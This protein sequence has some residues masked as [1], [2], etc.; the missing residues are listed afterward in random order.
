M[1]PGG[2]V[3]SGPSDDPS[4]WWRSAVI[5]QV[6]PRSFCD[7]DGDGVGDLAGVTAHLDH[8]VGL[9]VDALWL[10]PIF[11]S[12]MADFGYDVAD[13]CGVDPQ[14][15]TLEDF[16]AL[17]GAAHEAGLKL[18]LDWVPNHTSDRHPW[19]L[20][21]RSRPSSPR[22]DWYIWRR[23]EG[24]PPNNWRAAFPGVG[25]HQFPPA[26]TLDEAS[27]EWYLHLF[28]A[29][30]PDLNW[31]HPQVRQAMAETLRFWL[32]RGV[33]GFR[34][35]VIHALGKDPRLPDLPADL[36]AIPICALIDDP[37]THRY[38]ADIRTV[39][40]DAAPDAVVIGETVLP[41]VSQVGAFYGDP[42]RPEL[43]LAF[44]FHPLHARW[45]APTWRE[46][47]DLVREHILPVGWPAWALGNHDNPRQR[48]RYGS[49]ARARA[50]A[51][52]L[53]TLPG[54]PFLY[55]GE[56]LGLADAVVGPD[57]QVDPGGRDGCRAPIPW[58]PDPAHGWAADPWLPWPAEA[59]AG[60]DATSQASDPESMLTLYR[61]LLAGRRVSPALQLGGF[62]WLPSVADRVL[63]YRR[64]HHDDERVV[65]INFSPSQVDGALSLPAGAWG[66]EAGT[67][68]LRSGTSDG[69]PAA[70]S[71]PLDLRG[72]EAVILRPIR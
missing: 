49:D 30:Q 71:H 3:G 16:D 61:R 55:G 57:R 54:T 32:D 38:V 53:L 21:A 45:D 37:A 68:L 58:T 48:T 70:V 64:T 25:R 1:T 26:W 15:G 51:V 46:Q 14:F 24:G 17:V 60:G 13:Y 9:G 40:K 44:N 31:A 69:P 36:E 67:H 63:A 43:D 59:E 52:L 72:D 4:P 2:P 50:A 29:Q 20:S 6:Y 18:I 7:R 35:D 41:T 28:L 33:D 27:G 19:F 47:I 65:A 5:Y 39:V 66:V 62:D 11:P 42:T 34:M 23:S 56:E 12:P 10:S 8:L 22:R